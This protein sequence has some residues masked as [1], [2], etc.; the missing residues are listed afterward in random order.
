M[1]R[2]E[3]ID[4]IFGGRLRAC[5]GNKN[6][7]HNAADAHK[8]RVAITRWYSTLLLALAAFAM[9]SIS[10][11]TSFAQPSQGGN[12]PIY[13]SPIDV[14][15]LKIQLRVTAPDRDSGKPV[16]VVLPV[17]LLGP[18]MHQ[19]FSTPLSTQMDQYWNVIPDPKTGMTP[20]QTA[21]E[22]K[23]GIKQKVAEQVAAKGKQ[24][25][26][27]SCNLAT[28]GQLVVK[29]VGATMTLASPARLMLISR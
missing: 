25:Y 29:Q 22:G 16:D 21:C 27:I 13:T 19:L 17:D 9:L 1:K 14:T 2:Y 10:S 6:L 28:K 3:H 7:V 23:D 24:A 15:G 11:S 18:K 5:N 12:L 26:D 4:A 20:R 8:K